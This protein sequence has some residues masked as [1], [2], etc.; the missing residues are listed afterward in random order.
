MYIVLSIKY[1]WHLC[2]AFVWFFF[3][4]ACPNISQDY[5][6]RCSIHLD[7]VSKPSPPTHNTKSPFEWPEAARRGRKRTSQKVELFGV[8][9]AVFDYFGLVT[10]LFFLFNCLV[11]GMY[12]ITTVSWCCTWL[13]VNLPWQ[14]QVVHVDVQAKEVS[15]M[16]AQY[17]ADPESCTGIYIDN[18]RH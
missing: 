6:I 10:A 17:P 2:Y 14:T 5:A 4:P 13:N 9:G 18:H 8:F 15:C 3:P 1:W 16:V 7:L 12:K 11:E